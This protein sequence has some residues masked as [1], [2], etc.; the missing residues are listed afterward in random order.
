MP[1]VTNHNFESLLREI[2]A[3][4]PDAHQ[5]PT[6]F[7][8]YE[9]FLELFPA[10]RLTELTLDQ[11]C[12]GRGDPNTFCRWIERGL[13]PV[14]G[15]Y[16]P[17][18]SRGHIMYVRGDGSVYKNRRLQGLSDQ[19]ALRYTLQVQATIA[20][21]DPQQ[22]LSWIDDDTQIYQRA[23]VE[24]RLTVG[25]GRKLRLLACYHPNHSLPISSSDHLGHFLLAL[26]CPP[27]QIPPIRQPIARMQRLMA[28]FELARARDPLLTRHG[29]MTALYSPRLGLAPSRAT[30]QA[31]EPVTSTDAP[32]AESP[33]PLQTMTPA[34][35]QI[36]YGPPGTGK[37]HHTIEAAL[38]ILDPV[39]L[40]EHR[41][42]RAELKTRFDQLLAE[43][44]IRFVTFHQS[45]SY[46]D[47][48]EGIRAYTDESSGQLRYE[49]SD[50]VFKTLCEA[51]R[52]DAQPVSA[53]IEEIPQ[54][55]I[56]KMSLGDTQG[57]DAHVYDLC[58]AHGCILLGYG[59]QID[60][61]GCTTRAQIVQ[62]YR[63][64]GIA[65]DDPSYDYRVTSV[66]TFVADMQAGDL[67]VVS[68]GNL[69]F[70]AI[71]EITGPYTHE[72]QPLEGGYAQ[73]RSV[74]WLRQYEPSLAY[75]E[76]MHKKFSQM[77]LYQLQASSIDLGRLER[78]LSARS[79]PE[80][81]VLIIDEINRGNVSRILG[82]LI[83]LIEPS[84]RAGAPEAL[85]VVLPYSKQPFS[86]PDNVYLIGTMNTADRSL[87]SLDVALRRRFVFHEMAPNPALLSNVKVGDVSMVRLLEV[88][89]QRIEALLDRDHALG[90]AYF[91]PLK[92]DN[93][94]SRLATIFREQV[95]PLLQE[96]F[97]DDWQRIQWVLNDHRKANPAYR[98][99]DASQAKASALFGDEVLA[100]R[101]SALWRVNDDA[102]G[103]EESYLGIIDHLEAGN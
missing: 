28:Y 98:F 59:D 95:I 90:H 16:A 37:T 100:E 33:E 85:E 88:M 29:F 102:F 56:W 49:V 67:V 80:P 23:R 43:Q 94:L 11:Y 68:D 62:R 60:F 17:G 66:L 19:Q 47:F 87:T 89:N 51:A 73:K 64:H 52:A 12:V 103:C 84:K 99:I 55:R 2:E 97:F 6:Q 42:Q 32:A 83:T 45:Y 30:Q 71:G 9:Q 96:Y 24:P 81:R 48:V 57:Q 10:D 14:L 46:E 61:T 86:I 15:R 72:A 79:S 40:T 70:R 22:D 5:D 77:T 39:F 44:K 27:D 92:E 21:A 75:T 31:D 93:R 74:R 7:P 63:E 8:L 91:L 65:I 41:S 34:H 18:T 82:D 69:K 13:E 101:V 35:N 26:G 38:E 4:G 76:L 3:M 53:T 20:R 54:R 25:D 78:H 50:G 1:P 36:F 58:M